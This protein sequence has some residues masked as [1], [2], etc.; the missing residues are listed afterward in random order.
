MITVQIIDDNVPASEALAQYLNQDPDIKVINISSDGEKGKNNCL[1]LKPDIL[2]LDLE[3]PSMN[4]IEILDCI[5][6]SSPDVNNRINV[7]AISEYFYKYTPNYTSKLHSCIA[8]PYELSQVRDRIKEVYEEFLTKNFLEKCRESC[9]DIMTD[10]C[11]KPSN[12]HT[13]CL[14]E[15]ALYLV[16]SQ[17][18][19]FLLTDIC[20]KLSQRLNKSEEHINWNLERAMRSLKENCTLST[21]REV[22]PNYKHS[23]ITLKQLISLIA[24]KLD[25]AHSYSERTHCIH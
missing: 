5:C 6:K 12:E 20:E 17:K 2:L 23:T 9:Y 10:L 13:K 1:K 8:K 25:P 18:T 22:F 7:I 15:A 21:F 3:L 14:M 4:G 19:S 24:N 11:L 16:E